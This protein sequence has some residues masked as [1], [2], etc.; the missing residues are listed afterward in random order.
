MELYEL[1]VAYI[2]AE[3]RILCRFSGKADEQTH[4]TR[5]WFTRRLVKTFW[6]NL[7]EILQKQITFNRPDLAHARSE[8]LGIEHQANIIA[9][10]AKGRLNP[11]SSSKV[12]PTP[13]PKFCPPG[14]PP[15]LVTAIHLRIE[16]TNA[17]SLHFEFAHSKD[18]F[19]IRL[20]KETMHGF[21]KLL[22]DA[23]SKTDW[24]IALN[25]PGVQ[26]EQSQKSLPPSSLN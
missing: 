20:S 14:T 8:I 4:E 24:G 25:I 7:M 13:G 6:P 1:Q 23:V 16:N 2:F 17:I 22:Q 21:C 18:L 9:H 11:P 10:Q 3:D 5:C 19:S 15:R 26:V 12:V